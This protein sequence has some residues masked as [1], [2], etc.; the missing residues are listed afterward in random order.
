[1]FWCTNLDQKH[2]NKVS[3][4][5]GD[6]LRLLEEPEYD[7]D[8]DLDLDLDDL[9][10]R[11]GDLDTDR[12][13]QI[14]TFDATDS[15]FFACPHTRLQNTH[16]RGGK[17]TN[18]IVEW[19]LLKNPLIW[20]SSVLMR[21]FWWS[22]EGR[23]SFVAGCMLTI[24]TSTSFWETSRRRWQ[25][26]SLTRKPTKQWQR[27][28]R[29]HTYTSLVSLSSRSFFF[30]FFFLSPHFPDSCEFA[31]D[32]KENRDGVCAR[33]LRDSHLPS[34]SN[35]LVGSEGEAKQIK[36]RWVPKYS[37]I[38]FSSNLFLSLTPLKSLFL[39]K[40]EEEK[41]MTWCEGLL[42][43]CSPKFRLALESR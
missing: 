31:D 17:G 29:T 43:E 18:K 21:G 40:K 35:Q 10:L 20:S 6:A 1:M 42:R 16:E 2:N 3:N 22:F 9:E 14:R 30:Q 39:K 11:D 15:P 26:K 8:G 24:S 25:L 41:I 7:L 27:F 34:S 38:Y 36:N 4:L 28:T 13:I 19:Q 23:E 5:C 12:G 32:Q 33:R 37:F